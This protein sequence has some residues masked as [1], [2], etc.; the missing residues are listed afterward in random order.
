MAITAPVDAVAVLQALGQLAIRSSPTKARPQV[1]AVAGACSAYATMLALAI[2][3]PR[4]SRVGVR[5]LTT[6]TVAH[7]NNTHRRC[8]RARDKFR[9]L[10]GRVGIERRVGSTAP[11]TLGSGGA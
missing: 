11:R 7:E 10:N 6:T 3:G 1:R 8:D 9:A 4:P 5:I 2:C